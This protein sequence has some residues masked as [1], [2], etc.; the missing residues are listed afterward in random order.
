MDNSQ[1]SFGCDRLIFF[2]TRL[3]DNTVIKE[4]VPIGVRVNVDAHGL[5]CATADQLIKNGPVIN[6]KVKVT[7]RCMYGR[8]SCCLRNTGRERVVVKR[9]T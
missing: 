8:Y 6:L 2:L 1:C 3:M 4:L 5:S 7:V 9:R